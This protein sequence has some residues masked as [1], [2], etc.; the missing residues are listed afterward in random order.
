MHPHNQPAVGHGVD[1]A[2][3]GYR[4]GAGLSTNSLNSTVPRART[5]V[6]PVDARW[7][8]T[9][10]I[11]PSLRAREVSTSISPKAPGWS[12]PTTCVQSVQPLALVAAT[13]RRKDMT[14]WALSDRPVARWIPCAIGLSELTT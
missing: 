2:A 1:V 14:T 13:I 3:H 10:D 12:G 11:T 9:A 5:G 7:Y 6:V 8:S 4:C